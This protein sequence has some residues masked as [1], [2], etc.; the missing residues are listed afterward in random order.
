MDIGRM[1][2]EQRRKYGVQIAPASNKRSIISSGGVTGSLYKGSFGQNTLAQL[3]AG[4]GNGNVSNSGLYGHGFV[5][6]GIVTAF[7]KP[8]ARNGVGDALFVNPGVQQFSLPGG[9]HVTAGNPVGGIKI[10][11]SSSSR[12][13]AIQKLATAQN[14][15]GVFTDANRNLTS[16]GT[17]AVAT[18]NLRASSY[19]LGAAAPNVPD[20]GTTV[21]AAQWD[22]VAGAGASAGFGI[23]LASGNT[24]PQYSSTG[25]GLWGKADVTNP[26]V[27]AADAP[28]TEDTIGNYGITFVGNDA[29]GEVISSSDVNS[30]VKNA[31]IL[32]FQGSDVAQ[33]SE[34]DKYGQEAHNSF[35]SGIGK[36]TSFSASRASTGVKKNVNEGNADVIAGNA[37]IG[38]AADGFNRVGNVNSTTGR[39]SDPTNGFAQTQ[40]NGLV[41]VAN[42]AVGTTFG[43]AGLWGSLRSN[44]ATPGNVNNGAS[45]SVYASNL[46]IQLHEDV[47]YA[48]LLNGIVDPESSNALG[49]LVPSRRTAFPNDTVQG[50]VGYGSD[51]NIALS[52]VF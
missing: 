38:I 32:G 16:T 33:Y 41:A 24:Y 7:G 5:S 17:F 20:T 34:A 1:T 29:R 27:K 49:V 35:V 31:G 6:P 36:G 14:P 50:R 9:A 42:P 25:A 51:A 2:T 3:Q 12:L 40:V 15:G 22:A 13:N 28:D 23:A 8:R 47:D 37:V 26:F 19:Q 30:S 10:S 18:G 46:A 44:D 43:Q 21:T 48:S 52:A 4:L 39:V 45:R 11:K